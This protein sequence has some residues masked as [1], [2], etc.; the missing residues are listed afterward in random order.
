M[1]DFDFEVKRRD[2]CE[3][4]GDHFFTIRFTRAVAVCFTRIG[5]LGVRPRVHLLLD[6]EGSVV[7]G[8][9]VIIVIG[10]F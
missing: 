1:L 4:D 9:M 3:G 7:L 6:Y 10:E 8:I 2:A 5:E